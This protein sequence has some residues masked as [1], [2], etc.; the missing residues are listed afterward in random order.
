METSRKRP[1]LQHPHRGFET[2]TI[3]RAGLVDHSDSLGAA[4]RFGQGDVQWMT[5]G[6]G[7]HFPASLF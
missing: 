6:K 3:A 4:G 7:A 1:F 2:V 5:A